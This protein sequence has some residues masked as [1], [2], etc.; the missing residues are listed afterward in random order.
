ML[1]RVLDCVPLSAAEHM[2][3]DQV[4]MDAHSCGLVPNTLR[5]LQF[6]P[7]VLVGLHQ[8]TALEVNVSY[9]REH[10]I[11]I[12]RRIT[13]GG[14]LYWGP[15]EL[16]WEL[17]AA[18]NTPGIPRKVESMYRLLCE[19]MAAGLKELGLAAAY[20]PVNDLEVGGRK[21][22]GTGG[23]ELAGSFNFQCSLLVDF[24]IDEMLRA[25]RFPPE[26]LADKAVRSMRERVTSLREE[27][28]YV[29]PHDKIKEAVLHGL[30]GVLGIEFHKGELTGVEKA[31]LEKCLPQFRS[32]A[33]IYGRDGGVVNTVDCTA[34]YKAPGGLIRV[35]LRLDKTVGVIK[36]ALISGDFFA[37]PARA[38]N[39]LETALKNT[40]ADEARLASVIRKF[41]LERQ[42]TIPGVTA[43]HIITAVWQ[44]VE[45]AKADRERGENV[46]NC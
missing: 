31:M 24:D 43:Q 22:A 5:F 10:G 17:Y 25:L 32:D 46:G 2:A 35:Q 45:K 26:K 3:L 39:D 38:V 11:D 13:G 34:S 15:L 7:C 42:V 12:N 41:F 29:P 4:I 33:W 36:Y 20:R 1:F 27:L 28:G 23:T 18:K 19:A 14:S 9:C 30:A 6:K 8:N 44:T 21:I 40:P 37:Y 16:G